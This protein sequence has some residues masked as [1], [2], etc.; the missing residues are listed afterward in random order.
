MT[1][2]GLPAHVLLVH[3]VVVVLPL[4]AALAILGTFWRAAQRK[5]TF[6]IP[7]AAVVGAAAV[8]VTTAAGSDLAASLGDPA[9]IEDHRSLGLGVLPWA[10]AL[11]VTTTAQWVHLRRGH[12]RR[13]RPRRP[14]TLAIGALVVAS[15]VGTATTVALAGDS[16][17][18]A[19]WA[20]VAG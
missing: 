12:P 17:A 4:A 6:L 5:L 13:A 9:F 1:V 8:P 19:V 18:R 14:L 3:L 11:A 2:N 15:A 16:G 10:V 20:R 7:L